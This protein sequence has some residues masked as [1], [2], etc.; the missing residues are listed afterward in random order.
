MFQVSENFRS[1]I[2]QNMRSYEWSGLITTKGGKKYT[3]SSEDIVKGSGYIKWQ[4]CSDA[5]IELGSVYASEMGIS[6]FSQIDRYSLFEAEVKL[7]YTLLLSDG[8][9][10]TIPMGIFEV[11]EANRKI[12]TLELKG[13]DYML[14]FDKSIKLDSSS[15]TPYQFLKA[16]CD[17]CKVT[18]AQTVNE[19]SAMPN[20]K[21]TLGIYS[22]N[23]IESFRD[24][25]FYIAQIL[26][27]F[28]QIDRYGRLVIKQYENTAVWTVPQDSRFDSS[29]S[30]FV[31]R[32]TA[33][34]STNLPA[35]TRD[36]K[37]VV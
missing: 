7:F 24:L 34:S 8:T 33:V 1:A 16:A 19:I 3:F 35:K 30:D 23:D 6:L 4:C 32:Y 27:G 25:I 9:R 31:T 36:R 12:K 14:R 22:D 13:Y 17:A 21:T 18:M 28:C 26:G 5:E 20:G 11:T 15:G 29:Y 37:S 2:K 10:E